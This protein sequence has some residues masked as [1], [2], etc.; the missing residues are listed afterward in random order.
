MVTFKVGDRVRRT[1]QAAKDFGQ[2]PEDI[3]TVRDVDR[4][5]ITVAW[6]LIS[7]TM[8]GGSLTLADAPASPR[9]VVRAA[10]EMRDGEPYVNAWHGRSLDVETA[11]TARRFAVRAN[12]GV[13][14]PSFVWPSQW[15]DAVVAVV[16]THDAW[17]NQNAAPSP[18][19]PVEPSRPSDAAVCAA[20]E[21]AAR[22][23]ESGESVPVGARLDRSRL[24][25]LRVESTDTT[26][27]DYQAARSRELKRLAA[28]S[29]ERER[30]RVVVQCQDGE[31]V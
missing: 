3:G 15:P 24:A 1:A 9:Y 20:W 18:P 5:W 17:H 30:L 27:A 12:T 2:N 14:S 19:A 13:M 31:E 8:S 26:L 6:P 23:I 7:T 11:D 28:A 16:D 29:A 10:S 25:F 22:T 4:E 21:A